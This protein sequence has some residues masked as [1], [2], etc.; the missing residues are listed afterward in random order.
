MLET[1]YPLVFIYWIA[2]I[3]APYV[4]KKSSEENYS[5]ST[6][7]FLYILSPFLLRYEPPIYYYIYKN[8]KKIFFK[9]LEQRQKA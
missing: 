3:N 1:N 8:Y 9:Y 7:S 6:S 2:T 5:S 4:F